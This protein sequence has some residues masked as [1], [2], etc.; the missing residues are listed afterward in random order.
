MMH[1]KFSIFFYFST[2]PNFSPN[3][4]E[5]YL[6]TSISL[7]GKIRF[8]KAFVLSNIHLLKY[9]LKKSSLTHEEKLP[10]AA[11]ITYRIQLQSN[12]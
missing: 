2:F 9:F 1:G 5:K 10:L 3:M 11:K 4:G 7:V 12:I 8:I 6:E